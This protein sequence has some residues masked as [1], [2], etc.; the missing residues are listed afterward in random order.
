MQVEL[1]QL[2]ARF[3]GDQSKVIEVGKRGVLYRII[4]SPTD[5]DWVIHY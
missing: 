2:A 5:P 3:P 1:E 4:F